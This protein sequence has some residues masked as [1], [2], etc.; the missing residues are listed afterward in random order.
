MQDKYCL[1]QRFIPAVEESKRQKEVLPQGK[2]AV[3]IKVAQVTFIMVLFN[4]QA[5]DSYNFANFC[6]VFWNGLCI[7][8][9]AMHHFKKIAFLPQDAWGNWHLPTFRTEDNVAAVWQTLIFVV[10]EGNP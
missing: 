4:I 6:K 1:L 3:L 7:L 8:N 10:V 2:G 9:I 5:F